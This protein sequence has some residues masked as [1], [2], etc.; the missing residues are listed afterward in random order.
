MKRS[1]KK[2]SIVSV[3]A[4]FIGAGVTGFALAATD[5]A[6]KTERM[7]KMDSPLV[8]PQMHRMMKDV[9]LTADQEAKLEALKEK[10]KALRDEFWAVFTEEQKTQMLQDMMHRPHKDMRGPRGDK[11]G[12]DKFDRGDRKKRGD[13]KEVEAPAEPQ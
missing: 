1:I 9:E 4:L 13:G 8:P 12:G 10:Q 3:A 7:E 11:R 5:A 2:L 6:A